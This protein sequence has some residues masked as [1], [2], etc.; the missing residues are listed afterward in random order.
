MKKYSLALA[1]LA[2]VGCSANQEEKAA[3]VAKPVKLLEITD[4]TNI[5]TSSLPG[6]VIAGEEAKITFKVSGKLERLPIREGMDIKKGNIIAQLEQKDYRFSYERQLATFNENKSAYARAQE[7]IKN[8]Y[9]S[10]A[11]FDKKKKSFE[12]A[13]ADLSIAKNNLDYATLR[14]PFSGTIAKIYVDNFQNVQVK[15]AIAT[16]QNLEFL[17]IKVY[18]PEN[19]II[20]KNN[21]DELKINVTFDAD[22]SKSYNATLYE[23]ANQADP[24]TQTYE[25]TVRLPRP[26]NLNILPGMTATV[27]STAVPKIKGKKTITIPADATFA[28][29]NQNTFVWVANQENRLEK[30][31]ISSSELKGDN[32]KVTNGLKTGEKVVIA[33]V[34]FL[35]ENQLVTAYKK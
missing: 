4:G 23:L 20:Q 29:N 35:R 15:E 1:A 27:N 31:E 14:A 11:D 16:L 28:D 34:N 22:S 5:I 18:V 12:V 30:R 21:I 3:E 6:K 2:L 26:E 17:D 13:K 32:I 9:I 25:A 7:L 24:A 10:R 8:K 19:K 33:G